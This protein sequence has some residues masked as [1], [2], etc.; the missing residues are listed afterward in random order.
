MREKIGQLRKYEK[1]YRTGNEAQNKRQ[2]AP[3]DDVDRNTRDPFYN[4][5]THRN[6]R[7][8]DTDHDGHEKHDTEPHR[9][10]T[11]LDYRGVKDRRGK[12]HE[13]QVVNERASNE[14]HEDYKEHDEMSMNRKP[15][16]PIR[17]RQKEFRLRQENGRELSIPL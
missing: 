7:D 4:E 3:V 10:I 5:H 14:V 11:E 13:G 6:R 15:Y 8:Y 17:C 12:D 16:D 2:A 1:Q 9:V